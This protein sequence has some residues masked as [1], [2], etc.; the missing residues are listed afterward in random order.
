[1]CV[2]VWKKGV[3]DGVDE[4]ELHPR[5]QQE[6]SL[7]LPPH[8]RELFQE[9]NGCHKARCKDGREDGGEKDFFMLAQF[10]KK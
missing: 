3:I 10:G 7:H 5:N 2:C 4:M 1:M 8:Q 9:W 6:V